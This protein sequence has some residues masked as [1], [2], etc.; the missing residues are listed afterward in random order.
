ARDPLGP[1]LAER[2]RLHLERR[3]HVGVAAADVADDRVG[4]ALDA[5]EQDGPVPSLL[6]V[7]DERRHLE[8]RIHFLADPD[9]LAAL[10]EQGEEV[11][12][13]VLHGV[14]LPRRRR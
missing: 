5:L 13:T 3:R 12:E 10:I 1:G 9:E 14:I 4:E 6:N 7:P 11:A 2:A 8:A